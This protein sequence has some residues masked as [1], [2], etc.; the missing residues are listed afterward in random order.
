MCAGLTCAANL[1]T[2]YQNELD[3]QASC[4][5]EMI[6]HCEVGPLNVRN[7]DCELYGASVRREFAGGGSA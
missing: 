5:A 3:T 1:L 2:D 6:N 4:L 7:F